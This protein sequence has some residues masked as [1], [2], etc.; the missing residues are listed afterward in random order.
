MGVGKDQPFARDLAGYVE[1][2]ILFGP[3]KGDRIV[4]KWSCLTQIA[5]I[6][7]PPRQISMNH[8]DCDTI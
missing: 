1:I 4:N 5:Y 8:L 6:L 7:G 3:F 2:A